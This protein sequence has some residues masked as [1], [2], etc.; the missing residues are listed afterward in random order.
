MPLV[1]VSKRMLLVDD[2][3]QLAFDEFKNQGVLWLR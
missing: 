3:L 1:E 2:L